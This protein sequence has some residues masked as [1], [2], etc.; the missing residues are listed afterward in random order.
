MF[1]RFNGKKQSFSDSLTLAELLKAY[2][3]DQDTPGI[4]IALNEMIPSRA[5]WRSLIVQEGDCI[6]VVQAVQG[7]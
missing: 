7:G 2:S 4:A 3:I 1:V 6:E 5:E